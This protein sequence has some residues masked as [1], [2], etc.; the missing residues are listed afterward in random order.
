MMTLEDE[1]S[2]KRFAVVLVAMLNIKA[3][4]LKAGETFREME[5]PRCGG[6]LRIRLAGRRN[7]ARMGCAG[8][9]GMQAME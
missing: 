8:L 5:C 6:V 4:M 3:E 7:H 9:C 2:M 1:E